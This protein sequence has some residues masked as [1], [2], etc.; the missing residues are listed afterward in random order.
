[1]PRA[2]LAD[3]HIRCGT[4]HSAIDVARPA[5][6]MPFCPKSTAVGRHLAIS[7][8]VYMQLG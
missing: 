5:S 2:F 7:A 8:I 1:M 6:G 4:D 3:I